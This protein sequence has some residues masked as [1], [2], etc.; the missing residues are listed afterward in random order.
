MESRHI[1]ITG[2]SQGLGRA[3][4]EQFM[5]R[6]HVVSG[7][8]RN[9]NA[10][11]E[12]NGLASSSSQFSVVDV[13]DAGNVQEWATQVLASNGP[14][15][16]LINNA[17]IINRNAALWDVP[18][19]EFC[20]LTDINING[21]FHVIQAFVPAMIREQTG[22]IVNLSS[23]WGRSTSPDVAPYCA[24]KWAIEGLTRALASE[25]PH[26]MAAVPLNPGII[27]TKML[28]SC[29]GSSASS[30]PGPAQW[31]ETAVPFLLQLDASDNGTPHTAP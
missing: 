11:D 28:D 21:T 17:A 8:A 4:A 6:G 23:G 20:S 5:N 13:S 14:P 9:S 12:L 16:L 31:A 30:F 27:H 2:V 15:S 29:F 22:V 24:T 10:I 19:K 26:G 1:V 3:M 18:A 25:L 7:C